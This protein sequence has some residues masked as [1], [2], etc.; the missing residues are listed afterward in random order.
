[1]DAPRPCSGPTL[2]VVVPTLD[3]EGELP[4]LLER[5]LAGGLDPADRADQ[6][7]VADGGSADR[8]RAIALEHGAELASAP[9]GRGAQLAAGAALVSSDVL[10]FLHAD[11][12]PEPGALAR[13]RA[14][15]GDPQLVCSAMQQRI[16]ARGAFYRLVERCADARVRVAGLVYGDSGLAVRR[17]A[18]QKSGGFRP[19]PI[20]EDLDLSRRLQPIA[21]PRLIE[22]AVLRVSA[23]RWQRE[24]ALRATLRNWILSAAYAAGASPERLQRHYA[25][26]PPRSTGG[27]PRA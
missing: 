13:L 22:G 2:G 23:R 5:L 10:L 4:A 11:T 17:A 21:R 1:M 26:H 15:F 24:G 20:F 9:R 18:Y 7:V 14:A 3:E 8:T 12:R 25:P 6:V 16:D 27:E 19:L